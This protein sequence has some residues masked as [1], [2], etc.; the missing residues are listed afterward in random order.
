MKLKYKLISLLTLFSGSLGIIHLINKFIFLKAT[1]N[2]KSI[3][4]E[5]NIYKWNLGDINYTA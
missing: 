5:Q 1:H 3:S 2:S 4:E